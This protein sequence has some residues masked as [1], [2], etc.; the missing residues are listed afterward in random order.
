[1]AIVQTPE[2]ERAPPLSPRHAGGDK[3][4]PATLDDVEELESS[5]DNTYIGDPNGPAPHHQMQRG[6]STRSN[7]RYSSTYME[8]KDGSPRFSEPHSTSTYPFTQ[9]YAA[10]PQDSDTV[11]TFNPNHPNQTSRYEDLGAPQSSFTIDSLTEP[12]HR[13]CRPGLEKC[14]QYQGWAIGKIL[15]HSEVSH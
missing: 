8:T 7:S 15:Q 5:Y 11:F 9:K 2:T 3:K 1:M 13:V 10:G 4:T 14:V 6:A 12:R